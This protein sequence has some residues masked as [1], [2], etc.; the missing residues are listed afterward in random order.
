MTIWKG[1]KLMTDNKVEQSR[2]ED[3]GTVQGLKGTV[4]RDTVDFENVE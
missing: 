2:T 3:I 4:L 1:L